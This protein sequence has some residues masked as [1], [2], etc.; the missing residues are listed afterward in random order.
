LVL[1]RLRRYEKEGY[2]SEGKYTHTVAVAR[3]TQSLKV[4][5]FKGRINHLHKS[6]Y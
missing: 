3:V 2:R 4:E 6:K 1:I 5:Y